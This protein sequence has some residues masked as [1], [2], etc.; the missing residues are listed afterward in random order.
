MTDRWLQPVG[1]IE[2]EAIKKGIGQ[3]NKLRVVTK[4]HQATAYINDKQVTTFNG[5]PPPGGGCIGVSGGSP[6]NAQNTWQFTNLQVM[7]L[8]AP[9]VEPS[10]LAVQPQPPAAQP[11]PAASEAR[12]GPFRRL[13]N[14]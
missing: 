4:G 14:P 6:E 11:S 1:W 7:D 12:T 10:P 8:Q 9:S 3:V 5:Q 13:S 2:S